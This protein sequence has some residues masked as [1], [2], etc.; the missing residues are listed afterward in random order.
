MKKITFAGVLALAPAV[1]LAQDIGS[2]LGIVR[3]LINT[4]LPIIIALSLLFF[5]WGLAKYILSAGDEGARS[6]AR[7]IMIWG[8]IILFVMVSVWGLVNVLVN[9]FSL[10][11]SET[12]IPEAPAAR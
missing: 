2:I 10:D 3:D 4:L 9:T 1:V 5:F 6:E 11:T 8:V 12:A 7:N